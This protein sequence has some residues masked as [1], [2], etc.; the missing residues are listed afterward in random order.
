MSCS[1]LTFSPR[2]DPCLHDPST[3]PAPHRCHCTPQVS[4]GSSLRF[5]QF[6]FPQHAPGRVAHLLGPGPVLR[7]PGGP[8]SAMGGCPCISLMACQSQGP[9]LQRGRRPRMQR[10]HG[11]PDSAVGQRLQRGAGGQQESLLHMRR[12]PGRKGLSAP[13][14]G[15][16][17]RLQRGAGRQHAG[18][19][20]MHQP[21]GS[22]DTTALVPSIIEA[23]ALC[24]R[25]AW[26]PAAP[27][28]AARAWPAP[29]A[30]A[31]CT[32]GGW[33]TRT[34]RPPPQRSTRA[35]PVRLSC[36][37]WPEPHMS[38]SLWGDRHTCHALRKS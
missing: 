4:F 35:S 20:H 37:A 27:A 36:A 2:V 3:T 25:A 5:S 26:W 32:F 22:S 29:A 12:L 14:W 16:R 15:L 21:R 8:S 38:A 30:R 7:V 1:R 23:A 11:V 24:R 18:L 28:R 33:T 19:A 6:C 13:P 9:R 31:G 10:P 34:G 17:L